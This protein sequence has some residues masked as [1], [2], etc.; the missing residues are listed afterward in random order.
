[1]QHVTQIITKYKKE[2]EQSKLSEGQQKKYDALMKEKRS[3]QR[4]DQA[5]ERPS[6]R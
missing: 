2:I 4:Q 1:M 6:G 3:G 5:R